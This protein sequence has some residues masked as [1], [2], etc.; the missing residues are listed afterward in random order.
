MRKKLLL[1]FS[2]LICFYSVQSQ[3]DTKLTNDQKVSLS[4]ANRFE[5]NGWTY[6]HIEGNPEERGFQHGYLLANE[7]DEALRGINKIWE[8]NTATKES[9]SAFITT[10]SMTDYHRISYS[11]A[12]IIWSDS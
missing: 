10:G 11:H 8:Y 3:T 5:K 4:K 2:V 9:C 6:I 12:N 7:I 1:L